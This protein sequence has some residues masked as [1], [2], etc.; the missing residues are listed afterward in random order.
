MVIGVLCLKKNRE[1]S[2]ML[3][4]S[5]NYENI[6]DE[7]EIIY[8]YP[9]CTYNVELFTIFG[10]PTQCPIKNYQ[11]CSGNGICD[12]DWTNHIPKCF[13][14]YGYYGDDC[15]STKDVDQLTIY[16]ND[17]DKLTGWLIVVIVLLIIVLSI[18]GYLYM[19]FNKIKTHEQSVH[20]SVHK[21]KKKSFKTIYY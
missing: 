14:Y 16:H 7:E 4:C 1:F 9:T 10:C 13:C 8:E 18:L 21:N 11:L 2:I 3:Y 12:M 5:N 19:R 20:S 6:F 17:N 15:S